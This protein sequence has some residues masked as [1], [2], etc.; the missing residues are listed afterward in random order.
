MT[1]VFA[2]KANNKFKS[3]FDLSV[4][5][6]LEIKSIQVVSKVIVRFF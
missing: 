2:W 3:G 6:G 1:L 4:S 5:G